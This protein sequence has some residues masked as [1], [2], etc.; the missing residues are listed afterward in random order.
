MRFIVTG[1]PRSATQYGARLFTEL[2]V[3]CEHEHAL[4]PLAAVVDTLRWYKAG[5]AGES[6]WMAWTLLPLFKPRAFA[7]LV[8]KTNIPAPYVFSCLKNH[9]RVL[10]LIKE[11]FRFFIFQALPSF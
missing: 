4:R 6:S 1:T 3:T 7:S 10:Y 8:T 11:E 2:G 9:S 5:A